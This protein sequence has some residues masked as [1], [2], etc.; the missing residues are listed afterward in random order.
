MDGVARLDAKLRADLFNETAARMDIDVAVIEKDFWVCWTLR[1]LFGLSGDRPSILFKGGTSLSKAFQLIQRFSEDI[2]IAVDRQYW[3]FKDERD[4]AKA[5]SGKKRKSLIREL[6]A[7][8]NEYVAGPLLSDLQEA[9]ALAI[10]EP[11]R[12]GWELAHR[13]E[14]STPILVFEYPHS[15][16]PVSSDFYLEP[17]VRLELGSRS[18]LWPSVERKIV[19]YAADHFPDFFERPSCTLPVLDARR[20]F[21]EKATL[22]HA[23]YHGVRPGARHLSRHYYDVVMIARAPM[24]QEALRDM[25]LLASVVGFKNA[26]F[27]APRARYDEARPGTLR[28]VPGDD[29]KAS[30]RADYKSMEVMFFDAFPGF[31]ELLEELQDV[32]T[33]I[34]A[35]G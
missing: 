19:P 8:C 32:E 18:D 27:R 7:T 12:G 16:D 34:N 20:T 23:A 15:G 21:W 9:F 14:N 33:Q 3:G 26:Y 13:E 24:G 6:K 11:E 4:P 5:G 35:T 10:E 31:D 29:L 1:K 25:N 2:D 28:L 22:L 17:S 30:L